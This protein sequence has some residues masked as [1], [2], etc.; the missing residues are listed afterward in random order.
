MNNNPRYNSSG[1][2]DPVA[3]EA[4]GRIIRRERKAKAPPK[5]YLAWPFKGDTARNTA[6]VIRYCRFAVE[7]GFFPIA[8]HAYLPLFM[9]DDNPV[10][11]ELALSFGLRLLGGC[12]Q[13]W[14]FG[15]K[16]TE[17]MR[18]EINAANKQGIIIRYFN[19]NLEEIHAN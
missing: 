6:N 9:D 19:E 7:Q 1:C 16:I 4:I 2:R 5:V 8:P 15:T 12:K 11:R 13:L 18:R 14:V 10:E 3:Y 17:G